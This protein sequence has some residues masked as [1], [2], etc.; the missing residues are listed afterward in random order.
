VCCVGHSLSSFIIFYY[1][2]HSLTDVQEAAFRR[3]CNDYLARRGMH[4]TDLREDFAD[5]LMLINLLEVSV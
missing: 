4:I 1:I 2:I 5:G 3:W